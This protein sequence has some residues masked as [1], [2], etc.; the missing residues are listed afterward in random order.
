[1]KNRII[2]NYKIFDKMTK[3]NNRKQ[4]K[5]DQIEIIIIIIIHITL[6]IFQFISQETYNII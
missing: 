2:E 3:K 6:L 5:R 4:K 1:L